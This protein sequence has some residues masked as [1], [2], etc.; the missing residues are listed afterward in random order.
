[1]FLVVFFEGGGGV[2]QEKKNLL[3]SGID[4]CD[5]V[6]LGRVRF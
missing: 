4:L 6:G 3:V 1:L 5:C 2:V